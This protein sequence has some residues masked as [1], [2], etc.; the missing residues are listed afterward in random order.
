MSTNCSR[1]FKPGSGCGW[2]VSTSFLWSSDACGPGIIR[3]STR[4][5]LLRRDVICVAWRVQRLWS[6]GNGIPVRLSSKEDLPELW[7]PTTTSYFTCELMWNH[8]QYQHSDPTWGR[9]TC[10]PIFKSRSLSTFSSN[11]GFDK[12]MMSRPTA[13]FW[14]YGQSKRYDEDLFIQEEDQWE[15]WLVQETSG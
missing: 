1:N 9:G 3:I 8:T 14:T 15:Y 7:S 4:S 13:I 11:A 5:S 10:W 6:L 2:N 12:V